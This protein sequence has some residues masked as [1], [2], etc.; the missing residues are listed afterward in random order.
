MRM[1]T[2]ASV[3]RRLSASLFV[4]DPLSRRSG[5]SP[6]R[7]AI[8]R[9]WTRLP[10]AASQAGWTAVSLAALLVGLLT[11]P[12]PAWAQTDIFDPDAE[13]RIL[14]FY[15]AA[16]DIVLA[17][18]LANGVSGVTFSLESCGASRSDY[19]Q[20]AAVASGKLTLTSNSLG[21]V[22]GPNTESETVCTVTGALGADSESQE[23]ELYTVSDRTPTAL[24]E[25]GLEQARATEVD[26]R[27]TTWVNS[28]Y[29][30]LGWRK[31]GAQP[32]FRVVSG[33]TSGSVLTIPSL[34]VGTE[35]EI[36]GYQL[37]RQS[38]DLYRA[39]NSGADLKLIPEG[40]HD[41]SFEVSPSLGA[42][43]AGGVHALWQQDTMAGH[44]ARGFDSH[45]GRIETELAYGLPVFGRSGTGT[46]LI[47]MSTSDGPTDYRVGYRLTIGSTLEV[48]VEAALRRNL[49][50]NT[51]STFGV[52]VHGALRW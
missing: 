9:A 24:A 15:G 6:G 34:E 39:G 10:D 25:L 11:N 2:P 50:F 33:V 40:Q 37:T 36:R 20:A 3:L 41:P 17:D 21:H 22:H 23:F 12:A 29:V 27:I 31:A 16:T 30:R 49:R 14:T 46:P 48:S 19:Y 1:F 51:P 45:G 38:F 44:A 42:V 43:N 32:K 47:G 35:Y 26:I 8:R 5:W 7:P 52:L 18:Y 4:A 13:H 28:G